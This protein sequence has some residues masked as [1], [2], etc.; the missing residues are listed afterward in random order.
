[1]FVEAIEARIKGRQ[2]LKISQ[3]AGAWV[4]REE[5]GVAFDAKN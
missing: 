2:E 1:M 4:L 5:Y 3:E